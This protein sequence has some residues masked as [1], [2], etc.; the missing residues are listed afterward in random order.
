MSFIVSPLRFH[1]GDDKLVNQLHG[2]TLPP[3]LRYSGNW[4]V[5]NGFFSLHIFSAHC[6]TGPR[7]A[8]HA[9]KAFTPRYLLA[10]GLVPT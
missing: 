10:V 9:R 2:G 3:S 8:A 1:S 5:S 4:L 7:S 6:Y